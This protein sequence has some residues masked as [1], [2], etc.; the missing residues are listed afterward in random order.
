MLEHLDTQ[1]IGTVV[2]AQIHASV[3]WVRSSTGNF[4]VNFSLGDV[5]VD[6][7]LENT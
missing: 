5:L 4:V 1:D 3:V 7:I 6:A 2:F